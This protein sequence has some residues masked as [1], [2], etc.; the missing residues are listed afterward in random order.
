MVSNNSKKS[1]SILVF[2]YYTA[3]GIKDPTIISEAVALIESLLNDLSSFL[4]ENNLDVHFLVSNDFADIG[5]SCGFIKNDNNDNNNE[6]NNKKFNNSEF[7]NSESSNK[8][9]GNKIIIDTKL[10]NWLEENISSF[11]SCIFI[12]AEENMNLYNL[13]KLIEDNNVK[14]Y[15]SDSDSTLLCSNKYST[16]K[17]L[18]G[19]VNQPK[20]FRFTVCDESPWKISIKNMLE[21]F[22]NN[23]NNVNNDGNDSTTNN[24]SNDDEFKL[25]VKP[26]HGVDCQ[27]MVLIS[28][29]EDIAKISETYEENSEILVQEFIS[30]EN[31]S[32]SLI[33]DGK[34][35]IPLTLN[36]Q[37]LEINNE[38]QKYLG[39]E[40][41]YNHPLKETA[42]SIAKKAVE[43]IEGI[44]GFVG[45][46]LIVKNYDDLDNPIN[47]INPINSI[48]SNNINNSN[49]HTKDFYFLEINSRFTTPYVGISKIAKFNIG[50]TIIKLLDNK[51]A[52][53][54]IQECTN[55]I[56]SNYVKFKKIG[57]DLDIEIL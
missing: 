13:T 35:A 21:F 30:G 57:N 20:T 56:D 2:E 17:Y 38:N 45:V 28:N 10:E 51:I 15:G 54:S 41:P 52:I 40:L 14:I 12:S 53:D 19:I 16:F 44:K 43:S 37:Y 5:N 46:D 47:P 4:P 23:A 34:T 7:D 48:N 3:S 33:S 29:E 50:R 18:Q 39:G 11:D 1:D 31:L 42:F 24:D 55:S 25:I 22:D 8:K 9:Y 32:V 36:K 27:N 6:L 49:N 26:I